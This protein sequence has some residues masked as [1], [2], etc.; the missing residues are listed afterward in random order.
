[1]AESV[2]RLEPMRLRAQ[3]FARRARLAKARPELVVRDTELGEGVQE[4][5]RKRPRAARMP[6]VPLRRRDRVDAAARLDRHFDASVR[7]TDHPRRRLQDSAYAVEEQLAVAIAGQDLDALAQPPVGQV[8]AERARAQECRRADPLRPEQVECP[9]AHHAAREHLHETEGRLDAESRAGAC[10]PLRAAQH[11]RRSLDDGRVLVPGEAV[12]ALLDVLERDRQT[13]DE[14]LCGKPGFANTG[15][16]I[17]AR[18]SSDFTHRRARPP[19]PTGCP[20]CPFEPSSARIEPIGSL[21]ECI[22]RAGEC[23]WRPRRGGPAG[24]RAWA[25]WGDGVCAQ[26]RNSPGSRRLVPPDPFGLP[27]ARQPTTPNDRRHR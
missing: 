17:V 10:E 4:V 11:L 26:R 3:R 8:L 1:M 14:R 24:E 12:G 15:N 23:H 13:V 27:R 16:E 21:V 22:R 6:P 25:S 20:G 7:L 9:R 18:P 19:C 5:L 2:Q